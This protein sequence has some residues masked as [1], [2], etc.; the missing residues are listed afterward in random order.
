MHSTSS[1]WA[2][3]QLSS[4]FITIEEDAHVILLMHV[5]AFRSHTKMPSSPQ[6]TRSGFVGWHCI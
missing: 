1:S 4:L 3:G 2:S 6:D 5:C